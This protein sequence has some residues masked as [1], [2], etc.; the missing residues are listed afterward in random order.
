MSADVSRHA[1]VHA[2]VEAVASI[3]YT[4]PSASQVE[5]GLVLAPAIATNRRPSSA[6]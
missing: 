1:E 6:D 4:T 2:A 3:A 5:F